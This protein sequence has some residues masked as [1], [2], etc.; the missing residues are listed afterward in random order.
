MLPVT[1]KVFPALPI[2]MV[3]SHMSGNVA[4]RII[5]LPSKTCQ[6]GNEIVN[7]SGNAAFENISKL[8]LLT[9]LATLQF[10]SSHYLRKPVKMEMEIVNMSSN[11]AIRIISLPSKTCQDGNEMKLYTISLIQI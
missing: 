3:R 10:K 4:I 1:E 8:K 5:S 7:M 11:V 6:D 9:C 2:V